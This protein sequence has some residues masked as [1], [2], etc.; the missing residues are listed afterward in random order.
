VGQVR[1]KTL[2]LTISEVDGK[3]EIGS[4]TLVHGEEARIRKCR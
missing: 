4:F 1:G 3:K 2:E